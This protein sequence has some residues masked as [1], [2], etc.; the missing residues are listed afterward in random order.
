MALAKSPPQ[1]LHPTPENSTKTTT[2]AP[3]RPST[4]SPSRKKPDKKT[5]CYCRHSTQMP[6]ECAKGGGVKNSEASPNP[7]PAPPSSLMP[8]PCLSVVNRA[9][10]LHTCLAMCC[11]L[12]RIRRTLSPA[13]GLGL[14]PLSAGFPVQKKSVL[15]LRCCAGFSLVS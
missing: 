11:C 12:W 9:S 10:S 7:C 8:Y 15:G 14:L 5:A 1:S 13:Q 3:S 2:P 6:S 4:D